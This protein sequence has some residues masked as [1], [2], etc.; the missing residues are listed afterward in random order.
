MLPF[1]ILALAPAQ[2]GARVSAYKAEHKMGDLYWSAGSAFDDNPETAWMVP[3]ESANVGEWIEI[4]LPHGTVDKVGMMPGWAKTD[5]TWH[6]YPR[7]KKVKIDVFDLDDERN[8]RQVGT[9]EAEF[10]D[11]KEWQIIDLTDIPIGEGMFGG[12]ARITV[13]EIYKGDD[14][15]NLG[16]SELLFYMK[17][18]KATPNIT[19]VSGESE[20]HGKDNL[21]DGN[22]KTFWAASTSGAQLTFEAAGYGLARVGLVPGPAGYAKPKKVQVTLSG[23]SKTYDLLSGPGTQWIDIPASGGYTGSAWGEV[24]IEF[25]EVYQG[26]K[27][28][29][30]LG[31]LDVQATSYEGI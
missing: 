9:T 17:E 27:P 3:G 4:D 15:P 16:V 6:D 7:I 20:G 18:M 1:V 10:Q 30:A 14:F 11:K 29:I 5:E 28:E 31:D 25:L 13:L 19:A 8:A 26:T 22:A 12:R 2:A 21:K 24:T 23:R